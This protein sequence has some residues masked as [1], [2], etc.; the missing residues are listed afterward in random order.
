MPYIQVIN[1]VRH[2]RE[3]PPGP[4]AEEITAGI[5]NAA[6]IALQAT[7]IDIPRAIED[8]YDAV[9]LLG[10]QLPP[11]LSNKIAAKKAA[12]SAYLSL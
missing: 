4:T 2:E 9:V 7:D 10:S 5:K 3:D 11:D 8:L 12:R 6:L 1:G